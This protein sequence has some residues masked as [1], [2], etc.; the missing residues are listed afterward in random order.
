MRHWL[1]ISILGAAVFAA[2]P[3]SAQ[4]RLALA[5]GL[6]ISSS[7][8][9]TE[10]RLQL[11]G[12]AAAL[13][14]PAVLEAIV[15]PAG[16]HI[17]AAAYEWSGYG[18]Q[19]LIRGW[20]LLDSPAAIERFADTLRA[21]QRPNSDRPTA[22]GKGVQFGGILLRAAPPCARRVLDISGDGVNNVGVG[23]SYFYQRG[24]LD[25]ATVNG[26]VIRGDEP[27][28]V[29]YY[30]TDVIFGPDAFVALAEN[31]RDYRSAMREK[32]LREIESEMI[33]GHR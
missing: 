29:R 5:F 6:D 33:T 24:L 4:C 28:P 21:H 31:F 32:L 22:L 1:A 8:S 18:Q 2:A 17:A 25:G 26:L 12:L 27:D 14:S 20:T 15:Q 16:T 30:Q 11:D 19:S 3:S 23:P 10:Y 7:V 13:T 9:E